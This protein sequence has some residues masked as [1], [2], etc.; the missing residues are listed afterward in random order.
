MRKI[1]TFIINKII[2]RLA[3]VILITDVM[4]CLSISLLYIQKFS[5]SGYF[6]EYAFT[7]GLPL[8][9]GIIFI[10]VDLFLVLKTQKWLLSIMGL[11]IAITSLTYYFVLT[12]KYDYVFLPETE[13]VSI[14]QA[15]CDEN[16]ILI[17]LLSNSKY[18]NHEYVI[19]YPY[20]TL[21][22]LNVVEEITKEIPQHDLKTEEAFRQ[23]IKNDFK[24]SNYDIYY[25]IDD[26]FEVNKNS[27]R[28]PINTSIENGYY[29]DTENYLS[30]F[31]QDTIDGWTQFHSYHPQALIHISLSKPVYDPQTGYV[32][33]YWEK[34]GGYIAASGEFCLLRYKDGI[35]TPLQKV[36][37][38]IS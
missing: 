12:E 5:L 33:I 31:F 34:R 30:S 36:E 29:I 16:N 6:G 22:N 7:W 35:L 25:L 37:I 23:E 11:F 20:S 10:F 27:T 14:D 9:L 4:C 15:L 1:I 38:W 21:G 24:N 26:F 19:V 13:I 28:L 3:T 32:L 2:K 8:F 17:S 18:K